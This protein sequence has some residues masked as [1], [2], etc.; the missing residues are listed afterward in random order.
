MPSRIALAPDLQFSLAYLLSEMAL[1]GIALATG[2]LA[3]LSNPGWIEFQAVLCCLFLTSACGALGG[4]CCR[5]AAGLVA[6]G[7][8]SVSSL[9]LLCLALGTMAR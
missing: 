5:M 1:I 8:F 9:P 3:W 4:L 2:R 6:G 7:I